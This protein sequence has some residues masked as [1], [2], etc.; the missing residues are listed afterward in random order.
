VTLHQTAW[1]FTR[2][3]DTSVHM[4]VRERRGG[5][6]LTVR[7]PGLAVESHHFPD[8]ESLMRFVEEQ[9][10]ELVADGFHLQA[11]AERRSGVERRGTSRPSTS[12][13]RRS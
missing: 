11:V 6:H 3:Q 10:R 12:D 5:L 2:G 4:E 8:R 9:E 7:G 13:R 1:L